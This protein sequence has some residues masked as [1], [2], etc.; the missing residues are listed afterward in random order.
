MNADGVAVRFKGEQKTSKTI[1]KII[2]E[3]PLENLQSELGSYLNLTSNF[4]SGIAETADIIV[5]WVDHIR[6]WPIFYREDIKNFDISDNARDLII[7]ELNVDE[8]SCTEFLMSG[9]VAGKNTLYKELKCLQPGELLIFNK[10]SKKL[11]L[12]RYFYY[13]PK[14]IESRLTDNVQELDKILNDITIDIIR[15]ANNRPIWIPLSAGLDSRLILCKLHE[16]GYKNLHTFTY[17]PRFNF[18]AKHAK[19]IAK[20]LGVPWLF[21]SP[22]KKE[23]RSYFD[24]K[25]RKEFWNTTDGLKAIPSMREF[26]AL[27][28][29]KENGKIPSNAILING[30]SGDY[31]TGGHI[32]DKW[33]SPEK[34]DN[35]EFFQNLISKHYGLWKSLKTDINIEQVQRRIVDLLPNNWS[36]AKTGKDWARLEEIWE[37]DGR[38]ICLVA[39]GQR[40]YDFF[41]YDWEMP[42][43]D[44]AIVKFCEKLPL[45][46]KRNQ[47]LYKHYLKSYNYKN[48]FPKEE[49]E[50]WRWPATMIW[51]IPIAQI[52]GLLGGRSTKNKFYALMRYHGHYSNQYYSFS[53]KTHQST[54]QEARNVMSL[55]VRQWARENRTFFRGKI[56]KGILL[57]NV[58]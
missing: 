1:I 36:S 15:R 31:I 18:E 6:S 40:S 43:W 42:L 23:L 9:Y 14:P 48:L 56:L 57:E 5:A 35:G 37:Y 7:D 28:H 10:K 20:K 11:G 47:N 55:N 33:F 46:Q 34:F 53:W 52:L 4:T 26:T 2:R 17:G 25:H 32:A 24:S 44:K 41:G 45:D 8:I 54:F 39:N 21:V 58:D 3:H 12:R 49:P 27:F 50:I 30:Q 22:T 13:D 19:K 16:H 29:L 51:V 38:Q